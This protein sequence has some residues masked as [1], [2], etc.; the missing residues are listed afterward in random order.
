[1]I[2]AAAKKPEYSAL[3]DTAVSYGKHK[4]GTIDDQAEAAMDR[5]LVEFGREILKII[6]A[7]SPLRSTPNYPLTPRAPLERPSRS[8]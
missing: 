7:R 2:L 1:L 5:V 8:L 6:P 3:I 4:S